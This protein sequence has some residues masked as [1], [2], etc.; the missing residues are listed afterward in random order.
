MK[1][2]EMSGDSLLIVLP[3]TENVA[4]YAASGA[5][6]HIGDLVGCLARPVDADRTIELVTKGLFRLDVAEE[7]SAAV[8]FKKVY[9]RD[10]SVLTT[11]AA[12]VGAVEFGVLVGSIAADETKECL[13]KI[14]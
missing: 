9:L 10:N 3:G 1:N 5:P 13:V 12:A 7:T 4:N 2:Y 8:A 6:R 11:D 14:G